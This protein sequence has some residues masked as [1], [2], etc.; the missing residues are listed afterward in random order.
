MYEV[1]PQNIYNFRQSN[2]ELVIK[3]AREFL[4]LSEAQ[5]EAL[6]T[7]L[8]ARGV[9]KWLKARRDLIA[10]KKQ[11]KHE[12]KAIEALKIEVKS[13][14]RE[15]RNYR[16]YYRYIAL[17]EKLKLLQRIR[18]DLKS[19]C[20]TPR[21]QIWPRNSHHHNALKTMNTIKASGN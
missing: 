11:L 21:W 9:N 20:E 15:G 14:L 13:E 3:D 2:P 5:C 18:A 1:T 19:I 17:R 16:L 4:G 6:R 8:L 10:Y 12:I 7:I